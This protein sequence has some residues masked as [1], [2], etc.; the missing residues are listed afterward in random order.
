MREA[1]RALAL[2]PAHAAAQELL[3]A[4]LFELPASMPAEA[5]AAADVERSAVRQSVLRRAGIGYLVTIPIL[6]GMLALP[7]HHTWPLFFGIGCGAAIGALSL[8]L[9][10][11]VL[12]M[13][14]PWMIAFLALNC[15][16]ITTTGL[17]FG[18]L[19]ILPMFIVGSLSAF[20]SQPTHHNRWLIAGFHLAPMLALLAL[21]HGGV[22]PRSFAGVDGAL[23]ITPYTLDLSP[24]TLVI[25]F[26]LAFFV[27]IAST[28]DIQSAF[29]AA[30]EDA[31][32]KVHAQRWHLG[33]VFPLRKK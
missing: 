9:S 4:L 20:V 15:L 33:Q 13:R 28:F 32:N 31:Q 21:E 16:M 6:L 30:Q 8:Y 27:Q 26:A 7:L 5:L 19:L 11:R 22:L 18:A 29:R 23:V 1:G 12:P 2:D 3:A 10:R 14:S 17:L 25:V 24:L